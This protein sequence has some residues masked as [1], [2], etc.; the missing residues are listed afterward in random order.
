ML[1]NDGFQY[2]LALTG[3]HFT[4]VTRAL[5]QAIELILLV[6]LL[7]RFYFFDPCGLFLIDFLQAS[8]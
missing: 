7:P 8:G 4:E 1:T 5:N 3:T 6:A 2:F